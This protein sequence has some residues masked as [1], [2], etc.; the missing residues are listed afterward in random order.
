MQIVLTN[1][2]LIRFQ[3]TFENTQF[4]M[5]RN[6]FGLKFTPISSGTF[7]TCPEM[8][9]WTRLAQNEQTVLASLFLNGQL[10]LQLIY[11]PATGQPAP[12]TGGDAWVSPDLATLRWV[13]S[14]SVR[15]GMRDIGATIYLDGLSSEIAMKDLHNHPGYKGAMAQLYSL[16]YT[17]SLLRSAWARFKV[18]PLRAKV[19]RVSSIGLKVGVSALAFLALTL[20]YVKTIDLDAKI[21]NLTQTALKT[22]SE[23]SEQLSADQLKVMLEVVTQ[24]GVSRSNHGDPFVMFSDPNCPSCRTFEQRMK[25]LKW[26]LNPLIVPVSFQKGSLEAVGGVLCSKNV[27]KAWELAIAGKASPACPDGDKQARI[28]NEAF[29]SLQFNSTP[30]FVSMTGRVFR[31]ASDV[32]ALLAWAK[33]NGSNNAV[34]NTGVVK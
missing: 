2:W 8:A 28:N 18:L 21:Y 27:S 29:L 15:Q 19:M 1:L 5:K 22:R 17:G 32:Q 20:T 4:K 34:A 11:C 7:L 13:I 23:Q 25:E 12:S 16:A 26:P 9:P 33:A 3:T 30:T 6:T 10:A 14:P 31:G 24:S